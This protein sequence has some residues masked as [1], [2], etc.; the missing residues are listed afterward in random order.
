MEILPFGV[1]AKSEKGSGE[2]R[3]T[4]ITHSRRK[5]ADR[6]PPT[7]SRH[8]NRTPREASGK[9]SLV[10]KVQSIKTLLKI[11]RE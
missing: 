4:T 2:R 1:M 10:C 8:G 11:S 6:A 7:Q 3:T 5:V 9:E